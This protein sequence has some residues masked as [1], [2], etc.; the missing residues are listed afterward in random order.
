MKTSDF[1]HSLSHVSGLVFVFKSACLALKQFPTCTRKPKTNT[2]DKSINHYRKNY[3][4]SILQ[5]Y[6]KYTSFILQIL[7]VHLSDLPRKSINEV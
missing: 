1:I 7:E 3:M 5:V 6:F 4:G 2:F